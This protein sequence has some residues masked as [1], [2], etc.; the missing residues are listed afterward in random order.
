MLVCAMKRLTLSSDACL[1]TL[2]L[3]IHMAWADGRLEDSEKTGVRAAADVFNLTKELR[4]RLDEILEKSISLEEL[5]LDGLSARDKAFAFVAATWM[6]GVDDDIDPKEQDTL[7]KLAELL[8][9]TSDRKKELTAIARDLESVR[10]EDWSQDVIKLFR[11]IPQ[12]LE[13]DGS[14]SFE[15]AFD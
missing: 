6:T 5:L 8:G 4:A 10:G 13:G 2:A 7:D 9:F 11:A 1:E 3:M 14:E 12:R 15:V